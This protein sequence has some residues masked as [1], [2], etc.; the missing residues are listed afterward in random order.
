LVQPL[1]RDRLVS[2]DFES[3]SG[4]H[5]VVSPHGSGGEIPVR[6]VLERDHA[7]GNDFACVIRGA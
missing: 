5:G 1:Y 3:W 4:P 6:F 7:D 2:A